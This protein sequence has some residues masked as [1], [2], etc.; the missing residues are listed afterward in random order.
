MV[1]L[2]VQEDGCWS[3]DLVGQWSQYPVELEQ[4]HPNSVKFSNVGFKGTMESRYNI[5]LLVHSISSK[6]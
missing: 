4:A 3:L 6:I 1:W 2:S 5:L